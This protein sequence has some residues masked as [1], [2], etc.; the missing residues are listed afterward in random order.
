[1]KIV[2]A[3][4]LSLACIAGLVGSVQAS[5]GVGDA[6]ADAGVGVL[7]QEQ[8]FAPFEE[9]SYRELEVSSDSGMIQVPAGD[10][11]DGE[12]S[13]Q[14][15]IWSDVIEIDDAD[16]VRLRFGEVVLAKSTEQVRE[17]Y[18]RITSLEDGYEQYLDVDSLD[19]WGNTTAYF[20]GSAVLVE[21]MASPNASSQYNRVQVV[22][23]Q[24][25]DPV[26]T[27]S[28]CFSVDDRVLSSDPRD[29]RMMPIGCSVWLFGDQGSCFLTAGHCSPSSSQVVQ[30]NVP[31]SSNGGGTRN[32]PPQDQYAIDNASVQATGS[33]FIGNDWAFFGTFDNSTTGLSP[34]QAQGESHVLANSNPAV[35]GR[36]IRITGYGV[37]S[38]PVP[39]SWNQVQKTHV[40]PLVSINGNTVRYQ[41]DTT[42]GNSGS[43]IVDDTNNTSIGIH[44]NAGCGSGGGSN[45][46]TSLFN[47]GLQSALANPRGI[48]LPRSIQASILFEPTHVSPAGGDVVT[49][50]IDNLQGH[51]VVGSPTMFVDYGSGFV[52]SAMNSAGASSYEGTF[53]AI[54]CGTAISYYF[55]I[56]DEEG[57]VV[58]IPEAGAGGAFNTVALDGLTVAIEDDFETDQDWVSFTTG[59]SGAW[60]RTVP[61]DHGLG[62]PAS[63]ADGSGKCYVTSNSNGVD[64]DN[65]SVFLLSP[66][67][68]LSAIESPVL[69]MSIW[70]TGQSGDSF[71][72][73]FT[74]NAGISWVEAETFVSTNGWTEVE[75]VI[76]DFVNLSVA[77][78]ARIEVRDGGAD[79]T[80]EGGVDAFRI[81]S[82][83]C[84]DVCSA[85]LTGDGELNFFDVSAFLNAFSAQDSAADFTGDG[86]FNF[87]DVSA[88]LSA[89]SAGCP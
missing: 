11:R 35:D 27:R 18:L 28:I 89:F 38:S 57:T 2:C 40:G 1:M 48:C 60:I 54:D 21:L 10:L 81:A 6:P 67:V 42:G 31:L 75:Y 72:I 3:L 49:L 23:V 87:F 13:L 65:G 22:G 66:V 86:L 70:M 7:D 82:E 77:F 50:V 83:V 14:V 32:P 8:D 79:T 16:W 52:G 71:K 12:R 85:D 26:T 25:S 19:E 34:L 41:T 68:D 69:R 36:P 61:A 73:E 59:G 29:A 9:A 39:A 45:Q 44:T 33:V 55:E 20:N 37:T 76:S 15:A 53:S 88:F 17:S 24:A 74:D 46:G 51:S 84:N 62:D 80:V 43:S 47:S 64:V 56:E 30:F 4:G 5:G 58:S 78:R 63:D